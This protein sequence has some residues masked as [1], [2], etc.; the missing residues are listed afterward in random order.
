MYTVIPDCDS[1]SV[2]IK[3]PFEDAVETVLFLN[4]DELVEKFK[5]A[6]K[7][8]PTLEKFILDNHFSF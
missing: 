1:K 4:S 8:A 6:T 5:V 2:I 3:M 7:K